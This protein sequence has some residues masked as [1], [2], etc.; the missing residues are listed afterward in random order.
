M[1][2]KILT[3]VGAALLAWTAL[4]GWLGG[5]PGDH[6]GGRAGRIS[7]GAAPARR[8]GGQV[9]DLE[10]C[11]GCGAWRAPGAGCDCDTPPTP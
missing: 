7:G 4:R 8:D 6:R 3:L 2:W 5:S 10:R 1:I 9:A 11:A